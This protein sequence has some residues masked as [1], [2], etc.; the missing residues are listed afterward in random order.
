[1]KSRLLFLLLLFGVVYIS[2]N[3]P[4][5]EIEDDALKLIKMEKRIVELTI[6]L[7]EEDNQQLARERDSISDELQDLSFKLQ[8][9]YRNA[10][11]TKEFQQSYDELKRKK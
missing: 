5:A 1:M 6:Q 3:N 8:K 4:K 7:S 2:C 9:K 11:L 10:D